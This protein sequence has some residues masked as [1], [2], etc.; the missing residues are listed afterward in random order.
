MFSENGFIVTPQQTNDNQFFLP[1]RVNQYIF[2]KCNCKINFSKNCI[3]MYDWGSY[4]FTIQRWHLT[5]NLKMIY[6]IIVSY[7]FIMLKGIWNHGTII[8]LCL[9]IVNGIKLLESL[10]R[11]RN[12]GTTSGK[13]VPSFIQI[14]VVSICVNITTLS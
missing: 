8:A 12:Y 6:I 10:P 7:E 5:K 9:L 11:I 1:M 3:C 14:I 4:V 2:C 13:A